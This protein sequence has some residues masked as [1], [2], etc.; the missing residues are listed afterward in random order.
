MAK[1]T[2]TGSLLHSGKFLEDN[3]GFHTDDGLDY[4][5]E[6]PNKRELT[7]NLK[8]GRHAVLCHEE[9]HVPLAVINSIEDI[10]VVIKGIMGNNYQPFYD[11]HNIGQPKSD[12]PLDA[13]PELGE[14][15][16]CEV[17]DDGG[18]RVEREVI[19]KYKG[20][21]IGITSGG[22]IIAWQHARPIKKQPLQLTLEEIAQ[23]LGVEEV[24]VVGVRKGE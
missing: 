8:G 16:M 2:Y 19:A 14:G 15:V 17:W 13:L 1:K 6:L 21:Y 12:N 9:N 10:L 5:I 24:E 7:V 18:L 3:Y 4:T 20:V 22:G 11:F 23:R